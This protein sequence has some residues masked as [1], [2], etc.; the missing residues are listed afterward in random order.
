MQGTA[1]VS[2]NDNSMLQVEGTGK[3]Q[4]DPR[5]HNVQFT[6]VLGGF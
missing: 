5:L 1:S 6:D 2:V 4:T 3:R